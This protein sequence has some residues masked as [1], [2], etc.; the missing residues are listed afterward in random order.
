MY[1]DACPDELEGRNHLFALVTQTTRGEIAVIDI[2][3]QEVVDE[4]SV[5]PGYNFLPVGGVPGDI[6]S[7]PGSQAT[8]VGVAEPGQEGIFA[9]P[10][11]NS[12]SIICS[13]RSGS[14]PRNIVAS[15]STAAPITPKS[16]SGKPG[17]ARAIG[18]T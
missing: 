14:T 2:D 16:P 15:G 4:E 13:A 18:R 10:S 17:N 12:N 8:F 5:I 7:T 6:V 3:G 9:L 1:F 11:R